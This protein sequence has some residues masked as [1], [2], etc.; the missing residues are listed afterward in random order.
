VVSGFAFSAEPV[1]LKLTIGRTPMLEDEATQSSDDIQTMEERMRR[2]LGLSGSKALPV[3]TTNTAVPGQTASTIA[4]LRS[5]KRDSDSPSGG[6]TFT[7]LPSPLQLRVV[8][9]ERQLA[10]EQ[11]KPDKVRQLLQR[12][13]LAVHT[14]EERS[15]H[16]A[17][18]QQKELNGERQVTLRAQR[19]LDHALFELQQRFEIRRSA[20]ANVQERP[21]QTAVNHD[22]A[23]ATPAKPVS[24]EISCAKPEDDSPPKKR[25]RPRTRSTPEPKPVRWWTPSF[26]NKTKV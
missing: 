20:K 6:S 3:L 11:Q 17:S 4:S 24:N 8:E 10:A 9:L 21:R 13:E 16:D 7:G 2:A 5:A 23:I 14:L 1:E 12:T 25:G 19:S 22:A 26:R 18:V 15:Q